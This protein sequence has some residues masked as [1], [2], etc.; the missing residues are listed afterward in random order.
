MKNEG[1]RE[2][3]RNLKSLSERSHDIR[4]SVGDGTRVEISTAF[5]SLDGTQ[6]DSFRVGDTVILHDHVTDPPSLDGLL[7]ILSLLL[8][9]TYRQRQRQRKM[10]VFFF[11]FFF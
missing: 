2:K 5:D 3:E 4:E 7:S 1:R 11:F 6:F 10:S 9:T 8:G